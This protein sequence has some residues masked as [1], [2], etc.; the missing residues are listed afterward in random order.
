MHLG[1]RTVLRVLTLVSVVTASA[2]AREARAYHT[3]DERLTDHTAYTLRARDLRLG[4]FKGQYGIWDPFLVGTYNLPWLVR[5]ANLHLKWRYLNDE[6]W[7]AAVQAGSYRLDVSKL[8]AFEDSPGDAVI[9]AGTFEPS[10]SY[11]FDDRFTLQASTLPYTAVRAE[12]SLNTQ[13]FDGALTAAVD[14]LQLTTTFEWRLTRVTALLLHSRYLIF[15]RAFGDGRATLHPDEYTTVEIE[16]DAQSTALDF[17]GAWSVVPTVA[18]S[19]GTFNL[20]LGLGYGNWSIA[21][22]NFVLPKK[23]LIPDLEVFWVF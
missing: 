23:T 20:Q 17:K 9:T 22:L 3:D 13:A 15:Q 5:M 8:E 4:L 11:R 21:P 1:H 18:F 14:N 6:H 12:G 2:V 7:A 10:V 19:W 16:V